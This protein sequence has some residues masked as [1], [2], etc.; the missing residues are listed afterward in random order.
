ML[1]VCGSITGYT[2]I[3]SLDSEFFSNYPIL[4]KIAI[5][6]VACTFFAL[7]LYVIAGKIF[8]FINRF[9]G[10]AERS[11]KHLSLYDLI[12]SLAGLLLGVI[13]ASLLSLPIKDINIMG[14]PI[15]I[16]LYMFW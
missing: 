12:V 5:Y 14:P 6:V 16:I 13:I 2:I 3:A 11:V 1:A 10:R 4:F 7:L 8:Y 9:F 15:T